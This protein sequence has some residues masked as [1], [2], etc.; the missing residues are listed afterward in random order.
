MDWFLPTHTVQQVVAAGWSSAVRTSTGTVYCFGR[1]DLYCFGLPDAATTKAA[2][3]LDD[4]KIHAAMKLET[5]QKLQVWDCIATPQQ[6]VYP[7]V[8]VDIDMSVGIVMAVSAT[9]NHSRTQHSIIANNNNNNNCSRLCQF[10]C[11]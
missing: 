11:R 5:Q 9:G 3:H 6:A 4:K 10:L 2:A 7:E 1:N 8:I